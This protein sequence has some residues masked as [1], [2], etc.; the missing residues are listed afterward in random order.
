MP[1]GNGF[2]GAGIMG[3]VDSDEIIINDHTYWTGGPGQNPAYDGGFSART[4]EENAA[5]VK[6]AQDLLQ[7]AWDA[8]SPATVDAEGRI[9]PTT[10]PSGA[11]MSAVTSTVNQQLTLS[12]HGCPATCSPG[13][14]A[15]GNRVTGRP[16]P[17]RPR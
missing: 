7:S 16:G 9:T 17:R 15:P 12:D 11:A 13:A 4:S 6:K 5:N 14:R 2:I 8:T 10:T 1:P 3:G